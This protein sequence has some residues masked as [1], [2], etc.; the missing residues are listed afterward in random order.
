MEKLTNNIAEKIGS[1]LGFDN[2]HKEVIAYGAFAILQ[3]LLSIALIVIFGYVF[4][5]LAESL[6]IAFT[7]S[8]LRK[9][10][11]GVHASSPGICASVG[12]VI[13][14]GQALLITFIIIP[15]TNLK[16][17]ILLG[18]LAF[19]WSYYIIHKLAP[20]DSAAKPIKTQKK[21]EKMKKTSILILCA[22]MVIVVFNI[23]TYLFAH[24]KRFSTFSLCIYGGTSWQAFTLTRA[25]HVTICKIDAFI[26][27]ILTF[28]KGGKMI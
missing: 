23:F 18:L 11:G 8:I 22:Y 17:V 25:G 2:D 9:Y 28:I 27:H 15:L 10:S 4:G 19:S 20:V 3:T 14:V 1:E 24:D 5:V 13:A 7:I 16:L 6:T 26:N 12:T 21:K